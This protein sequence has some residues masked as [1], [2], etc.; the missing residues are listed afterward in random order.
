MTS[1]P[2]SR[3]CA[4][5]P[6]AGWKSYF[7][8]SFL[9]SSQGALQPAKSAS[10]ATATVV[11]RIM[12]RFPLAVRGDAALAGAG[13]RVRGLGRAIGARV[14]HRLDVVVVGLLGVA[15]GLLGVGVLVGLRLVVGDGLAV[16]AEPVE[17]GERELEAR[18]ALQLSGR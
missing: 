4:L 10:T 5:L 15:E 9:N 17:P 16:A 7:V 12:E 8:G 11:L 1:G 6:S 2:A 3:C 18:V 13:V 14:L